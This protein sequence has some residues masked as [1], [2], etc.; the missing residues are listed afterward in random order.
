VVNGARLTNMDDR[1]EVFAAALAA[2]GLAMAPNPN[3]DQPHSPY[4]A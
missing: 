1:L 3:T 2:L 4:L